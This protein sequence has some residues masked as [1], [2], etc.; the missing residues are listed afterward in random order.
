MYKSKIILIWGQWVRR[1]YHIKTFLFLA[2]WWSFVLTVEQNYLCN[3]GRGHNVEHLC[4]KNEFGQVVQEMLF[5]ALRT[6]TPV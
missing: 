6:V 4:E 1:I 5:K 3:F 2:R